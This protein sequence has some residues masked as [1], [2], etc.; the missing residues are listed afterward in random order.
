MNY[1]MYLQPELSTLL[2]TENNPASSLLDKF[3]LEWLNEVVSQ[4]EKHHGEKRFTIE[5][6]ASGLNISS[7]QLQRRFRRLTGHT[8]N[9]YIQEVRLQR[10]KK[11]L[12]RG[13]LL[14]QVAAEVG[15]RD[16]NYFA[17]LYHKRFGVRV[18]D[19]GESGSP[20]NRYAVLVPIV[21]PVSG[22]SG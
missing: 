3:D 8:V 6:L 17:Q 22:F 1:L 19:H 12:E 13:L 11:L 9:R 5:F 18:F 15:F 14:K 7:R 10:G 20:P 21:R 16:A 2:S 4:T